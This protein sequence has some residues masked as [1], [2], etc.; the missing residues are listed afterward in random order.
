[1]R[2][3]SMKDTKVE[4]HLSYE[5]NSLVQRKERLK[6]ISL[7]KGSHSIGETQKQSYLGEEG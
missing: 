7:K 5:E 4:L 1:M 2:E 6:L 3:T